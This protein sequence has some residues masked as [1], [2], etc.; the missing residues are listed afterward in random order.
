MNPIKRHRWGKR[1]AVA[2]TAVAAV[3]AVAAAEHPAALHAAPLAADSTLARKPIIAPNSSAR[4]SGTKTSRRP[5]ATAVAA[6]RSRSTG[7]AT[8]RLNNHADSKPK[9][10]P[11]MPTNISVYTTTGG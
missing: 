7:L 9:P 11:Q 10:I 8:S 2:V 4:L 6:A 5:A 3:V 1:S